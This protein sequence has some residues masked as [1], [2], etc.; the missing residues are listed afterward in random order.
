MSLAELREIGLKV[1][2]ATGSLR[3]SGLDH[4]T[5]RQAERALKVART[6]KTEIIHALT[7]EGSIFDQISSWPPDLKE[8][9]EERAGI[10]EYEGG[11]SRAE[12]EAAAFDAIN[13]EAPMIDCSAKTA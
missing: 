6:R 8:L 7:I 10:M 12:A 9:F 2:L 3:L 13:K 11:M 5:K 1:E 4:L